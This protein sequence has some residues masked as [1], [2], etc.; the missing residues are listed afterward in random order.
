VGPGDTVNVGEA[1]IDGPLNV[2]RRPINKVVYVVGEVLR[3]GSYVIKE[4]DNV[5]K[6]IALAGGPT[7]E[8]RLNKAYLVSKPLGQEQSIKRAIDLKQIIKGNAFSP[9]IEHG[10]T[11]MVSRKLHFWGNLVG[12]IRD[13]S[14]VAIAY[15]TISLAAE[16]AKANSAK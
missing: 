16:Q 10:D 7:M 12:T 5:W 13:L 15:G 9:V 6:A 4:D 14:T 1:D 11:I 3:P 2:G 8:A